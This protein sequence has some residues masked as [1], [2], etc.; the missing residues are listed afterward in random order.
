MPH[1]LWQ[2]RQEREAQPGTGNLLWTGL[3]LAEKTKKQSL[4]M[5]EES[6]LCLKQ[7][8]SMESQGYSGRVLPSTSLQS[9][10]AHEQTKIGSFASGWRGISRLPVGFIWEK[11]CPVWQLSPSSSGLLTELSLLEA[12]EGCGLVSEGVWVASTEKAAPAQV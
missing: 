4:P 1:D 8:W 3:Y 6:C 7:E 10:W 9:S 12:Q 2:L 5:D 11:L